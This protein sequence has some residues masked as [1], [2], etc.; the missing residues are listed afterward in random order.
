MGQDNVLVSHVITQWDPNN[1]GPN[2]KNNLW[3]A[4]EIR[5]HTPKERPAFVYA[6]P[7]FWS[8]QA[9]DVVE[10][11]NELGDEYVAVSPADLKLLYLQSKKRNI[12]TPAQAGV[13]E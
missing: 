3:L 4:E 13:Q 11:L 7:M 12:V 2:Q 5:Q 6:N 10:V 9:S 8:Y 1:I